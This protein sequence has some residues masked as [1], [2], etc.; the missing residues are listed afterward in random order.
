MTSSSPCRLVVWTNEACYAGWRETSAEMAYISGGR[1]GYIGAEPSRDRPRPLWSTSAPF[2]DNGQRTRQSF[3][4]VPSQPIQ[5]AHRFQ[6][7]GTSFLPSRCNGNVLAGGDQYLA[8]LGDPTSPT[9]S[10]TQGDSA[11]RLV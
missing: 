4:R 9:R 11:A 3:S 1:S 7:T 6:V 8:G 5:V 2:R 10:F